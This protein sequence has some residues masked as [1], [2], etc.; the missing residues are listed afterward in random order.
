MKKISLKQTGLALILATLSIPTLALAD[1]EACTALGALVYT[2]WTS[3]GAG[4]TG[5]KVQ[6]GEASDDYYRCKSC[7]GWDRLGKNGGH[8]DFTRVKG[9]PST[10][11]LGEIRKSVSANNISTG[12]LGKH[13]PITESMILHSGTGRSLADGSGSW[14]AL[15]TPATAAN[16]A[17]Y[18]KGYMLGN[19]HPDYTGLMTTQQ[20][21][22]LTEYLNSP[23]TQPDKIFK[24]IYTGATPIAYQLIDSADAVA[25]K[26]FYANSCESCH[27]APDDDQKTTSALK[28]VGGMIAYL[29]S[30]DQKASEFAHKSRWGLANT[31][32]SRLSMANPTAQNM[33]DLL[34]YMQEYASI[35]P[36]DNC[37]TSK[38][39]MNSL[40]PNAQ[41][42][43]PRI[44][45][46]TADG[47]Q[48]YWA[49][50]RYA[51]ESSTSSSMMFELKQTAA[52]LGTCK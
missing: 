16:T 15:T 50:L 2:N 25:G 22:C 28:P 20:L 44:T 30:L 41:L 40:S 23:D 52:N 42:H 29:K 18:L 32:M 39:T 17:A 19:Q 9:T 21:T 6:G 24:N 4:G 12:S 45:V 10:E 36:T 43:L 46:S 8:G 14:V 38:S 47:D 5:I 34:K 51:P 31:Q 49:N 37:G 26:A 13:A 33:A 35:S 1:T 27:G 3:L 48:N 11:T 7:H